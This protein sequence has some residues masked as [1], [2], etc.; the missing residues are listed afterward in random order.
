M[1]SKA[2]RATHRYILESC[3]SLCREEDCTVLDYGC[4]KGEIV[5]AGRKLGLDIH[6]VEKFY[7]G[8]NIIEL[9][10]QKG[11]LENEI[12]ELEGGKIPFPENHFDLV[13][14]SM[15]FEHVDDLNHVLGEISRVLKSNGRM[16]CLFPTRDGIREGHCGIAFAHWFPEGRSYR[17]YWL[18]MFRKLG[19]GAHKQE[20]TPRQWAKDFDH[21]L[22]EYTYHRSKHTIDETFLKYFHSLRYIEDDYVS[23]RLK[24][25]NLRGL[26]WLASK[27]PINYLSRFFFRIFGHLV[28]VAEMG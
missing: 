11:L 23:Y 5:I 14:S 1:N 24:N 19:F 7:G 9:V 12:R 16:L 3:Q 20:K 13:L 8:S 10:R 18:L 21:W 6:G 25:K 22:E 2:M 27:T 15:V 28:F 4:G 26:S 17:Y